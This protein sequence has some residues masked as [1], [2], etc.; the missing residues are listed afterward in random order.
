[1]EDLGRIKALKE[2]RNKLLARKNI[3]DAAYI[4]KG[5]RLLEGKIIELTDIIQ[6]IQDEVYKISPSDCDW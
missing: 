2:L 1:M 3:L 6:I 5:N 4:K